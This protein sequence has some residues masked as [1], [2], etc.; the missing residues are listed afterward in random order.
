MSRAART[1]DYSNSALVVTVRPA[2]WGEAGLLGGMAFQQALERAALVAGGGGFYAPAQNLLAFAGRGRGPCPSTCRPGVREA[3]LAAFLP[4]FVTAGLRRAL[5]H[6]D[7]QMRGFLTAEAVLIGVESRTS[8]PL[9]IVRNEHGESLSHPGLF[10]AGEGAGYAGG[11]MSAALDGL[12]A[13]EQIIQRLNDGSS[14]EKP[15]CQ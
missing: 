2:D 11:I 10:P 5:P 1:G 14:R 7:R 12:R 6:F 3:D 8:A 9:R 4:E 13:A 15:V